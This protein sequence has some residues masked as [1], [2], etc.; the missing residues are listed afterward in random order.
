MSSPGYH[1]KQAATLVQLAQTLNDQA[2]AQALLRRA[3]EHI[4]LAEALAL[5]SRLKGGD[6]S[7]VD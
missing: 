7:N 5:E 1:R 4:R 6:K 3:A 2:V